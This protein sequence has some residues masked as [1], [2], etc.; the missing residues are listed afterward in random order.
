M[1]SFAFASPSSPGSLHTPLE[2]P[3]SPTGQL[4][5]ALQLHILS[6]LP[7][8]DRSLSGRLVSPD[9]AAG[10][11]GPDHCTACLSQPLP[12]HAA[13]WAVEA[14]QQHVQQLPFWHKLQL[15]CTAAGS[16]SEVNL[17]V[18]WDVLQPSIFPELLR[19]QWT[20]LMYKPHIGD[21]GV[22]AVSAGHPQLLPWLLRHCPALVSFSR[23]LTAAARQYELA[24]LQAVWEALRDGPRISSG[25]GSSRRDKV[26]DAFDDM[27]LDAAAGSPTQDAIAKMQWVLAEGRGSCSLQERTVA[28][29]ARSGDLGRL[30]WLRER[31]CVMEQSVLEDALRHADLAVAQWMVDEVGC[32][33]PPAELND[34]DYLMSAAAASPDGLPK[35]QWLQERGAPQLHEA[36]DEQL[37]ALLLAAAG[38]GQVEV[39]RHLLSALS[40]QGR[41]G[42]LQVEP[43]DLGNAAAALGSIP[44]A[45]LLLRAGVVFEP[46]AFSSRLISRESSVSMDMV[47][48]LAT[49]AGVRV[50]SLPALW[51]LVQ[52]RGMPM[53]P[54]R[55]GRAELLETVQLAVGEG[56][57]A[58]GGEGPA[59]P[60]AVPAPVP[61]AVPIPVPEAVLEPYGAGAFP[62]VGAVLIPV[63]G[64]GAAA[65]GH[66]AT[67]VLQC[68]ATLGHLPLVQYLGQQLQGCG[69]RF[70]ARVFEA[71]VDA[72][73]EAL[74]EWLVEQHPG[75]LEGPRHEASLYVP[76]ARNGD[77]GTL[78]ALRRLGV[79]WGA[80]DVLVQAFSEG[81]ELPVRQWLVDQGAPV[82]RQGP[83]RRA[84]R[85]VM[86]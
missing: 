60:A 56:P 36:S 80:D 14:G 7:P 49:E 5:P 35:L 85:G 82:G 77:R 31:G 53:P 68:A 40:S 13:P 67:A 15:M 62:V 34:W 69:G 30:Q 76:A 47:R 64:A 79:P 3:H 9:A 84:L 17:E 19:G 22:A 20:A 10:L 23:V 38:A 28:A 26:H 70:G 37:R 32:G 50:R 18:A 24:G 45:Q 46:S 83:V 25:S 71:A 86:R 21:P 54:T 78:A 66:N 42:L 29:A 11:T 27:V 55:A 43:S 2:G 44:T 41:V 6:F 59:I 72:G 63:S 39:V 65:R 48:W 73:C 12:P 33:L 51:G 8:N 81:A 57:L 58:A 52:E 75:C 1:T 4:P 74:L 16:G 61:E